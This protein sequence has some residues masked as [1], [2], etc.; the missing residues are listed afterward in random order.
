MTDLSVTFVGKKLRSPIGVGSHA[1]V[2]AEHDPQAL[3]THLKGY[4]DAGAGYVYTPF[5]S[6][7]L[8]HPKGMA[9]VYKFQAM[10]AR[11]PFARE[12]LL[13]ATDAERI[14]SRLEE[15]LRL[16]DLLKKSLPS[17][18]PVIANLIGPGSDPEGWA[19]HC[20]K[21]EDAGADIIELNCSCPIPAATAS[22]VESYIA[23]DL[24]EAAGAL[25]GDSPA[26]LVPVVE[27]AVK[28]VKIPLGVKMTPETGFPRLVGLAE[29]IKKAG[30]K[31][32]TAINAPI[33]C[34]P[35]DIYNDGKGKWAGIEDNLICG[36][37]G[38]MNRYLCYRNMATIS[39]FVPGIELAACGGLVEP[40]HV[41]EAM[42]LGAR[43]AEFS[44]GLIWR[45]TRIISDTIEFLEKDYMPR[46]GYQSVDDFIGVG[47][48]HIKPCEEVD[49]RME[50]CVSTTDPKRCVR[51]GICATGICDARSLKENPLRL[52]VDEEM[53]YGC[54]LCLA[55]CPEHAVNIIEKKHKVI[56][57]S[58]IPSR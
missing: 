20:K 29:A 4:V 28:A 19:K 46:M 13:S 45:G 12:G 57:V 2:R 11:E 41:V 54:G 15:G 8:K 47:I 7:E 24:S 10:T 58:F 56:G 30:A 23:G 3:C 6:P 14:M 43:I 31:F 22:A 17:D 50:E 27:A 21:F 35:P 55:V 51:C 49:W 36:V 37:Q 32:I 26:L 16:L 33:T 18:V 40:E 34:G 53:C 38:P 1:L 48:K 5:I 25:L 44:A 39:M 42:M 9:P 52:E